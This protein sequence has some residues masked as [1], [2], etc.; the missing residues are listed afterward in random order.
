MTPREAIIGR[1]NKGPAALCD[2]ACE[3]HIQCATGTGDMYEIAYAAVNELVT[4]HLI[5][6]HECGA[7]MLP[8]GVQMEPTVTS[9]PIT[10]KLR[11]GTVVPKQYRHLV[12]P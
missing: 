4:E 9:D 2:L 11:P 3:V 12:E 5:H 8:A 10:P 6:R 1:I 7:Y